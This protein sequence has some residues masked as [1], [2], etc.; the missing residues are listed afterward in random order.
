MGWVGRAQRLA[1][2]SR[3]RTWIRTTTKILVVLA[4]PLFDRD[5]PQFKSQV[6][7]TGDQS[8]SVVEE[9]HAFGGALLTGVHRPMQARDDNI[10]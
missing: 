8:C 4:L 9:A 7:G 1:G 3:L 2:R 10:K 5:H 6:A